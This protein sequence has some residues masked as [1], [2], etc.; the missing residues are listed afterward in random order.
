MQKSLLAATVSTAALFFSSSQPLVAQ[1]DVD[2]QLGRV[3]FSTSCNE[4][5]QRRFDRGMRYQHSYWYLPAKDV[6]EEALKADPTCAMAQWGIALT[7]LD[8]P[9]NPIPQS[10]LAPRPCRYPIGQGNERKDRARARLH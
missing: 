10:N 4:V 3:Q 1:N 2:Q 6:F 5:A 8:N 7:L 9:H